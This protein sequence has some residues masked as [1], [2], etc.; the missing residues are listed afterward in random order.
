M[1]RRARLSLPPEIEDPSALVY[2]PDPDSFLPGHRIRPLVDGAETF[3]AML[4]AIGQARMFVHLESYI[5]EED[6]VG[7][8]FASALAA[9]AQRGVA[10]R[11]LVDGFGALG[12]SRDFIEQ[13]RSEGVKVAFYRPV[14]TGLRWRRWFRRDHRKILVCDGVVAFTGGINIGRN[15]ASIAEGGRGWRDTHVRVEGPVVTTLE[16]LFRSVW[17]A[18][19]GDEY[20]RYPAEA[21]ESVAT[22]DTELA[23]V[24]ASDELGNRT[25]IRRRLLYAMKRAKRAIYIASAYF[26][27][28]RATRR[29]LIRA[30]R[31]GVAVELIVPARS[32]VKWAQWA[33]EYKYAQLLRGG[34]RIHR[35]GKTHMHA[36]TAVVDGSWSVIGSYNLDYV[37]LL[38]NL[39]V[40][41]EV[42]GRGTATRMVEMFERDRS[43]CEE[44]AL[45]TWEQRTWLER[46]VQWLAYRFRRWL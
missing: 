3:P 44:L 31:R 40:V 6:D 26:V 18:S 35:W 23:A 29:A 24:M 38:M 11:L 45:E 36:K 13:L 7:R 17:L 42:I 14:V 19:A 9:A 32:D 1:R 25:T 4:A 10:V 12:L 43:S 34:V 16:A 39:E 33:G 30:A 15:Y 41:L 21:A 37:S 2:T 5:Y 46:F 28:D 20:P 22:P 27:P 8:I